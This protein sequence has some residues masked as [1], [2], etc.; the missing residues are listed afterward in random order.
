MGTAPHGDDAVATAPGPLVPAPAPPA[1]RF[2]GIDIARGVALCGMLLAHFALGGPE[3]PGWLRA[4]EN[5]AD[6]RAA[7]LFCLVLGVG[8]GLYLRRRRPVALARRGVA[9]LVL[10][11]AIWP[12]VD[13]V[14][15]ILP[16][17]GLL[18]AVVAVCNRLPARTL[19]PLAAACWSVP[20]I[21][22]ALVEDHGLRN[23]PQP[24]A[25]GDLLDVPHLL[26][27]L[28]WSGGYP[29][30]GWCG[31]A[32]VG[33]WI[34]RRD[35]AD[36]TVATRL[37]VAGMAAAATQPVAAALRPQVGTVLE[38]FLDSTAHSNQLAW[39][40]AATG[41]AVAVLGLSL[42]VGSAG[43]ATGF[44]LLGRHA[45]SLY[46]LHLV[47]GG[48]LVWPWV[49]GVA[50]PLGWQLAVTAAVLLVMW[51]ISAL[52]STRFR[53]GPVEGALRRVAP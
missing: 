19:L 25:Y 35:L 26:W 10:G 38:P 16:Q 39:Y 37:V 42:L 11:V 40:L 14:Y 33:L 34:A 23:A 5:V 30:I 7:P 9:L 49:E 43:R 52:W 1:G 46:L 18:L 22:V 50:R 24:E 13:R 6:G 20:S 2:A 53:A 48:V 45:L 29:L 12:L 8:S 17:Y 4:V 36:R 41:S 51:A 15:L 31:F 21:G 32:L 47:V 27:Q 44:L 3:D 28:L